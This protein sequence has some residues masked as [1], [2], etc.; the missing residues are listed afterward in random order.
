[1]NDDK[2][3]LL[4]RKIIRILNIKLKDN[5]INVLVQI[6]KFCIVG[7]IAT[8]IDWII[9]F[10]LFNNFKMNPLLANVF[11]FSISLIYNYI[12]SV[13]W[14]FNIDKEKSK[15]LMFIQFIVFSVVGLLLTEIQL[16]IFINKLLLSEMTS[17]II[18]TII[19]MVFNFVTRKLFLEKRP[20]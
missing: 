15:Q 10:I 3:D 5:S 16:F 8:M 18:A 9:Y 12:A 14:V 7:G 17:K 20:L 2:I 6:F 1:M 4:I 11:S 13:R 19:V